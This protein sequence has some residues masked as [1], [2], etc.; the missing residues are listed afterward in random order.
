MDM[1]NLILIILLTLG[2]VGHN[3][4]ISIAT[5][6]LLLIRLLHVDRMFPFLEQHGL[7]IGITILTIGVI[8]PVASGRIPPDAILKT[9]THWQSLLA[10][11]I[12]I[13][14]AYLGGKG[15]ALMTQNPLIISGLVVGTILGV[16]F[17]RGVPVG[18]LI[19]AGILSLVLQVFPK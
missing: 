11:A 2:V 18:P 16:T 1:T 4:A 5:I 6:F 17:F 3:S 13:F 19:A 14:V 8:T 7:E 10:V 15:T 9:F 12:G